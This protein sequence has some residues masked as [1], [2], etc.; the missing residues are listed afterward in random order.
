M[1]SDPGAAGLGQHRPDAD[2]PGRVCAAVGLLPGHHRR[3]RPRRRRLP[4]DGRLSRVRRGGRAGRPVAFRGIDFRTRRAPGPRGAQPLLPARRDQA[5][6]RH[7]RPRRGARGERGA[8]RPSHRAAQRTAGRAG[9]RLPPAVRRAR[10]RPAGARGRGRSRA[11]PGSAVRVRPTSDP[12]RLVVAYPWRAPRARA[13]HGARGRRGARRAA[14][15]PTSTRRSSAAAAA[16]RG[17]RAGRGAAHDHAA[18]ARWSRS[19]AP[20]ARPRPRG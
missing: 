16:G 7:Q 3:D 12:H 17:G 4:R 20:T 1:W 15:A 9:L 14:R 8:V 11:R 5:D 6:A 10:G 18:G 13:G 2:R 19:P